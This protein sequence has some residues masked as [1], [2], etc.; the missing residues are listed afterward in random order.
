MARLG[1]LRPPSR[2]PRPDTPGSSFGWRRR[3]VVLATG[4][5]LA[6]LHTLDQ[7][8][9]VALACPVAGLEFDARTLALLDTDGDG[10]IR[11]PDVLAAIAWLEEVLL[12]LGDL[13]KPADEVALASISAET[14]AGECR[15]R[16]A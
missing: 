1:N 12:E 7:K 11:P 14:E 9:W 13:F 16:S 10:R 5:D 8:L 4:A 6:N 3:S 2:W 15:R